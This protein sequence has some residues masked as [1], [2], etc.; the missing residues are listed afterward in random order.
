MKRRTAIKIISWILVGIAGLSVILITV[1][2]LIS[3]GYMK[4]TYMEPWDKNYAAKYSDPRVRLAA[5]GLL[6]ASNHNMQPWKI[7]LDGTNPS[8]FYLYADSSRMTKQVDPY[9]RQMMISEGT[10]LEYVEVAGEKGGWNTEINLFPNGTYDESNLAKS[11]DTKPVAKI[12]LTKAKTQTSPLYDAMFLPDTNREAYR[13]EK[14]SASQANALS[15]LSVQSGITVKAFQ[16][17]NDLNQIGKYAM[18]SAVIE[19]GTTRVMEESSVIFRANESQKNR[20]RYGYSVEG[21]G[22]TGFMKTVLQGLLTVFP[23]LN[24]GEA[25]S[26]NFISATKA[27]VDSTPAY[28]MIVSA[29]NSRTEQVESGMLYSKLVLT[30]HTL[31]LAMQP[32]SQVLEEYPEM[33][34]PYTEFKQAYAPQGGTVQM[35][36]RVGLPTKS[37][38]LSMRR[39]V[40]SLIVGNSK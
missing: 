28:V 25:A 7:A 15:S 36:F 17:Q 38:P 5:N 12:T 8:V 29:G 30:G 14:L 2:F 35:L 32:L 34:I 23:S 10:F 31:G 16:D 22:T 24:T 39:D 26:Q 19:A 33:K 18:Q 6:A 20:Y 37:T 21:Q 27:S 3:G 9:A 4:Q 1:L 13:T 11:M 40:Q